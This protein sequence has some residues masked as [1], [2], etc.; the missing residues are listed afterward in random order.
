MLRNGEIGQYSIRC[1][2]QFKGLGSVWIGLGTFLLFTDE[3]DSLTATDIWRKTLQC[4]SEKS[5]F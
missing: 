4:H 3:L 5:W 1:Q 2:E